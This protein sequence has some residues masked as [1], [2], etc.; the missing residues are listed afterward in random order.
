MGQR[1]ATRKDWANLQPLPAKRAPLVIAR[2][3]TEQEL[4]QIRLGFFPESMED[5]WFMFLE[6]NT[7]YIHRS[8]TGNCIYQLRFLRENTKYVIRD[9]CVNR[10]Q[11]QYAGSNDDYDAKL[12]LFLIDHLLLKKRSPLPLD[13]N[14][15]AGIFMELHHHHILGA[16]QTADAGPINVSLAGALKWLWRWL[17]WVMGR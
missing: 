17:L 1:P 9:A 4:E 2:E 12:L 8:W 11:T 10:D 7:L 16:G 5:K 13:A 15:P 6:E 3:F 14:V